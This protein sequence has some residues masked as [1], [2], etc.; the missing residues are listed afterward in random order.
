[1]ANHPLSLYIG[2]YSPFAVGR[3]YLRVDG[4]WLI[5]VVVAEDG[6]GCGNL[7]KK[8]NTGVCHIDWLSLSRTV[9][10]VC[11]AA[12]QH[13]TCLRTLF[14]IGVDPLKL[15]SASS[16]KLMSYSKSFIALST[17]FTASPSG[18]DSLSKN[19]FLCS[20]VRSSS[21]SI[22]VLWKV[23]E[24]EKLWESPKCDSEGRDA[25]GIM[26]PIDLLQAGLSQTFLF[27]FFSS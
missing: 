25:V 6:R 5:R 15:A 12:G 13:F 3:S 19:H 8:G 9:S 14:K 24:S 20:S 26:V 18:T 16:T 21:S 22:Q 1:M 11:N 27:F 10:L 4:C 7:L 2:S 17:I 23:Q